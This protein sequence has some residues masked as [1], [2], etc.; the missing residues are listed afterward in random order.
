M[1]AQEDKVV[2]NHFQENGMGVRRWFEKLKQG[3]AKTRGVFSGI[4]ELF[5]LR[6]KVDQNFLAV[7]E[8]NLYLAVAGLISTR[9]SPATCKRSFKRSCATCF[10]RHRRDSIMP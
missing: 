2:A 7:L 4:A 8:K 1:I 3:L 9:K 10:R 6:G 5:R